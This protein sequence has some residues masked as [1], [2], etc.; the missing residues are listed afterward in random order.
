M[1][2]SGVVYTCITGAYDGLIVHKFV[3]PAYD[4]VCFTDNEKLLS[5]QKRDLGKLNHWP[6]VCL[7]I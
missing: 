5:E 2:K 6:I 7:T 1:M 4:Y 3:N